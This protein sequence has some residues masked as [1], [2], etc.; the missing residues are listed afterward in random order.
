M[1]DLRHFGV[2]KERGGGKGKGRGWQKETGRLTLDISKT[3]P[4][5]C[6]NRP[7]E[8]PGLVGRALMPNLKKEE[9]KTAWL[10][11]EKT[12][13]AKAGLPRHAP[14]RRGRCS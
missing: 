6:P 10:D 5:P 7:Y 13:C 1:P 8:K 11:T 3:G 4:R 2:G 12:T 14:S 9:R